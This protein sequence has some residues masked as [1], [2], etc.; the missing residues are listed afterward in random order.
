M[1]ATGSGLA[2]AAGTFGALP[3]ASMVPAFLESGA[4]ESPGVD[5]D[6]LLPNR[7]TNGTPDIAAMCDALWGQA[8]PRLRKRVVHH[9]ISVRIDLQ[10]DFCGINSRQLD[11]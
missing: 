6:D 4:G 10:L 9:P 3:F 2:T 7:T 11:A 1:S 8:R 5:L